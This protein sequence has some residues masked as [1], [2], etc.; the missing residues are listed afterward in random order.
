MKVITYIGIPM[1]NISNKYIIAAS[2]QSF[3]NFLVIGFNNQNNFVK[4]IK[5][6]T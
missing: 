4:R 6:L 5:I 2:I 3:E 1:K